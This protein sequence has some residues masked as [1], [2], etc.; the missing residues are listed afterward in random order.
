M[1]T[2]INQ[3]SA[4]A[5]DAHTKA[6][7]GS[8]STSTTA[9]F[10][11]LFNNTSRGAPNYS[12]ACVSV[13]VNAAQGADFSNTYL[14]GEITISDWDYIKCKIYAELATT[15]TALSTSVNIDDLPRTTAWVQ[16][17][18]GTK[19]G[20]GFK[21]S[22]DLSAILEE[23][24]AQPGWIAGTRVN[25][26]LEAATDTTTWAVFRSYDSIPA[27]AFKLTYTYT[28]PAPDVDPTPASG[29]SINYGTMPV[30]NTADQTI[31]VSNV[32]NAS[33]VL[34]APSIT[35]DAA[36]DYTILSPSFPAAVSAGNSVEVIIRATANEVGA[37]G[38]SLSLTTNDPD[39]GTLSYTLSYMGTTDP[40]IA[41]VPGAGATIDYGTVNTDTS[42]SHEIVVYEVGADDLTLVGVSIT[43]TNNVDFT[44]SNTFPLTIPNGG[45]PVTL[46][47]QFRPQGT[48]TRTATLTI[49]TNAPDNPALVYTL[50]GIGVTS[51]PLEP[52]RGISHRVSHLV[53]VRDNTTGEITAEVSS[54]E[55]EA[56]RYERKLNDVGVFQLTIHAEHRYANALAVKD[57]LV[58]IT[59]IVFARKD[60]TTTGEGTFI[61][62]MIRWFEDENEQTWLVVSGYSLE[63]ILLQRLID[64]RN[65]PLTAGGYS[66]KSGAADTVMVSLVNEQAGANANPDQIVTYLTEA[67]PAGIGEIVGGRWA[68]EG[69]LDTLALLADSGGM[70]FRVVRSSGIALEFRAEV[71]GD[72]LTR[73]ANYPD[74]PFVH[75]APEF[76]NMRSP[77]LTIDYREEKTAIYLL[78]QGAGEHAYIYERQAPTIT[79]TRFSYAAV[80]A[81][82]RQVEDE[83]PTQ[84]LTQAVDAL[85]KHRAKVDFTFEVVNTG[86]QYRALWDLGDWVT[87]A[88]H[89]REFDMR[90]VSIKVDVTPDGET[91]T[92]VMNTRE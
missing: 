28:N 33:L 19:V 87:A 83:D 85:L 39:E 63:Y 49:T 11:G 60:M 50:T 64:P 68:W 41:A 12:V 3:V 43:G 76:G 32:G 36:A 42:K 7:D 8:W 71:I 18:N 86:R 70:D 81:D 82:A 92:P 40:A 89:G 54:Q 72:D 47:V 73:N 66:T 9:G 23:V 24:V 51:V 75:F 53:T 27:N 17:G 16:W 44:V 1:P 21:D 31:T 57:A 29:S 69:L 5:H 88:W 15:P 48:G 20:T 14:T 79:D 90:I 46:L 59:R 25:F 26:I 35:G 2:E 65:D 61:V 30:G 37:R 4:S 22:P 56:L 84:Y 10:V 52:E 38:A 34:S 67:T 77:D 45:N 78:G 74:S 55:L 62:R 6:P 13:Q 91:I 58:D 80:V